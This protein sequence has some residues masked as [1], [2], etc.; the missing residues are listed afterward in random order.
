MTPK[1]SFSTNTPKAPLA[2]IATPGAKELTQ[3]IDKRLIEW[4]KSVDTENTL[5]KDTF[6]IEATCP[7]F[8]N[9]DGKGMIMETVRGKDL[10]II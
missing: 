9:G 10:F 3:L 1:L 6:I 7:R 8:T 5:Q 4:Y 2:L